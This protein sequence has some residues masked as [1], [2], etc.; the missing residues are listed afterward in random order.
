LLPVAP[1][2]AVGWLMLIVATVSVVTMHHHRF[3]ALVLIGIIGL[4]ISAGFAYLSAPDLA[5]TQ[6]SV[7][8]V[9]IMLLL[10]ALHFMPKV[11]PKESSAGL[12]LRDGAIALGAGGGVGAL[13]YAFL[14]R[15][16]ETISD[17]HIA[18]S[19]EGGGG[20]NVV[21]VI[22]V[23]FRGYDTFGEI[24]VLGIAGLMIYA[25]MHALLDGPAA[26]RLKNSDYAQDRSRDRHP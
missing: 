1:V 5:L 10:L 18:N 15:D 21:N 16:I 17:Y 7:E 11:T 20:T 23:D 9:T 19:Y 13:A 6:I 25:L 3:R 12:K 24:I 22:L 8:T 4:S 26:R 14:M 2:I